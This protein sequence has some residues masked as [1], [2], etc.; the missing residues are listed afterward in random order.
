MTRTHWHVDYDKVEPAHSRLHDSLQDPRIQIVLAIASGREDEDTIA[1]RQ[2]RC[3]RPG[4][5]SAMRLCEIRPSRTLLLLSPEHEIQT[6][7]TSISINQQDPLMASGSQR[8][9]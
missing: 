4:V 3:Q 9:S 8:N 1:A 5:D 7:S 2:S 6:A